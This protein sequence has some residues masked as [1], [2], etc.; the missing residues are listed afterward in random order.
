MPKIYGFF[1]VYKLYSHF[2]TL[3]KPRASAEKII[4]K[5]NIMLPETNK[6][7]NFYQTFNKFCNRIL[8]LKLPNAWSIKTANNLAH[9]YKEDDDHELNHTDIYVD[10]S[11]SFTIP[12]HANLIPSQHKIYSMYEKSVKYVTLTNLIKHLLTF[13]TCSGVTNEKAK[14]CEVLHSVPKK[15]SPNQLFNNPTIFYRSSDCLISRQSQICDK[16][17]KFEHKSTI[18][19]KFKFKKKKRQLF[20]SS[21]MPPFHK[22]HLKG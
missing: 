1:A 21:Q 17:K 18:H 13:N 7:T 22:H 10:E 15:F 19:T 8:Q 14:K 2:S 4:E 5:K 11:L 12:I 16:C 3:T 20:Q 6:A 9:I